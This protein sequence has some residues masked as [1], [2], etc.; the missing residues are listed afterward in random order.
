MEIII[1]KEY[2]LVVRG[3][4]QK[5]YRFDLYAPSEVVDEIH[6]DFEV[7]K[8]D[9]LDEPRL[10]LQQ[11][12]IIE[13]T[14]DQKFLEVIANEYNVDISVVQEMDKI[15][16]KGERMDGLIVALEDYAEQFCEKTNKS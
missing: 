14:F 3:G 9:W 12:F 10:T 4:Y 2:V 15:L 6:K 13:E 1:K 16:G 7:T 11:R 5:A 8:K